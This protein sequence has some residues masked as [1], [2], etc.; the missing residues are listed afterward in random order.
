[1]YGVGR[2]SELTN[3]TSRVRQSAARP[4]SGCTTWADAVR[5]SAAFRRK[6]PAMAQWHYI[7]IDVSADPDKLDLACTARTRRTSSTP[8][9]GSG[10]C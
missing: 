6:Y 3:M 2:Q 7:N 10:T 1:V 8:S 9:T 4:H 5:S